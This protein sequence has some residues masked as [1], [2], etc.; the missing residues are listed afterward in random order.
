[1]P[2]RREGG[3]F[4]RDRPAFDVTGDPLLQITANVADL[5]PRFGRHPA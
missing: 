4:G 3:A 2:A 5:D 1:M